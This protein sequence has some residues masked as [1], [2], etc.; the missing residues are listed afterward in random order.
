LDQYIVH[1]NKIAQSISLEIGK[2][3]T[4][5][6]GDVDYDIGY[7]RWHLEHA[8]Q[9]LS[10]EI[11]YQNQHGVH[12]QYYEARGVTAVISPWNYPSSQRV[13]EVIPALL[14]GNAII[15]KSASAC[16]WTVKLLNDLL[17]TQLPD[18]VFQ[19]VYGD[20]TLGDELT[21]LPVS[22]IIFT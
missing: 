1:R 20:G 13:R 18:N 22:Q 15:Y 10:P 21:K 17:I 11:I 7:M 19:P 6:Y 16:I 12:T 14:A 5:A 3:I 4:H 8:E 2:A 9:M